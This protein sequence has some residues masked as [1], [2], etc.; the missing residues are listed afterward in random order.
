MTARVVAHI[1]RMGTN[2]Q[3]IHSYPF[4]TIPPEHLIVSPQ[5]I[6]QTMITGMMLPALMHPRS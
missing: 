4:F 3:V 5:T 6:I 1:A 2:I